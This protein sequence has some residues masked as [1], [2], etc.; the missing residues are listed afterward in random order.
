MKPNREGERPAYADE[1]RAKGS[2]PLS[3]QLKEFIERIIVPL[4]VERYI[5]ESRNAP[6][7]SKKVA[8]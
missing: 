5:E 6:A 2:L 8:Q 3:P 4:L 1:A 7:E